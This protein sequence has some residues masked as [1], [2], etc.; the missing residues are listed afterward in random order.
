MRSTSLLLNAALISFIRAG[1]GELSMARP[2][3]RGAKLRKSSRTCPTAG[4]PIHRPGPFGRSGSELPCSDSRAHGIF[5]AR[6]TD[7][8]HLRRSHLGIIYLSGHHQVV[9]D[10]LRQGLRDLGLEERKHFVLDI[11]EIKGGDW[12]AVGEAAR[13]LSASGQTTCSSDAGGLGLIANPCRESY[14]PAGRTSMLKLST[15]LI[16]IIA[17]HALDGAS[18]VYAQGTATQITIAQPAEA[19]T[20]DPGGAPRSSRSTT[21]TTSTTR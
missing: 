2:Y 6:S 1:V 21:S 12:Q 11:R 20:M 8:P 15:I 5:T 18:S 16:L 7:R 3:T 13:A 14:T 9:V 19:T 4:R 10:G 17:T